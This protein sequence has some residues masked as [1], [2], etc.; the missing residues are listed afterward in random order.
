MMT[1]LLS[2]VVFGL[3][4]GLTPGPLLTLVVSETLRHGT[5]EGTKVSIAPLLTD[6]PIVSFTLFI[7]SRMS[8]IQPV[9][10]GIFLLGSL[11]LVYLGYENLS[12]KGID[13]D[14][15]HIK[16]QSLKKGVVANFLNP[17]P[18]LFWLSIGAPMVLK[19]SRM[20]VSFAIFFISASILDI[21]AFDV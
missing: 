18:Y 13:F 6:L 7:L 12:F 17:H 1:F 3:S 19:A 2:G 21:N 14:L 15:E 5:K 16:P 11:F 8:D 10:G 9:I 4:A 20:H